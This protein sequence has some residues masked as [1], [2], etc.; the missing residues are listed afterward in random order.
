[1]AIVMCVFASAAEIRWKNSAQW[2][3]I[4]GQN[5]REEEES[6]SYWNAGMVR[7]SISNHYR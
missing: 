5:A 4:I 6:K 7:S 3:L 2:L 1:M